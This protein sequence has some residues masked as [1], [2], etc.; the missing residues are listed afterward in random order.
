MEALRKEELNITNDAIKY[1][2]IIAAAIEDD[3]QRKR[4]FASIIALDTFAD[5]LVTKGISVNISKNL[6]K[7]APVNAEFEIAD[8]YY[9]GWKLDVR[10]VGDDNILTIP[11]VHFKTGITADFYVAVKVD[12]ELKNAVIIGY[13]DSSLVNKKSK[14]ESYY[15]VGLEDLSPTADLL[16]KIKVNNDS[17]VEDTKHDAFESSYLGYIDNEINEK[18]K[19][20]LIKHL[21][22]CKQCRESFVEFFDFESIVSKA[23]KYPELFEDQTLSI[24]SGTVINDEN[25]KGQELVI[26]INDDTQDADIIDGLFSQSSVPPVI[27]AGAAFSADITAPDMPEISSDLTGSDL[28]ESIDLGDD[29]SLGKESDLLIS[30]EEQESVVSE[31]ELLDIEGTTSQVLDDIL[32]EPETQNSELKVEDDFDEILNSEEIIDNNDYDFLNSDDEV[33]NLIPTEAENSLEDNSTEEDTDG[34]FASDESNDELLEKQDDTL[35]EDNI[36]EEDF[37]ENDFI[38]T[39][40]SFIEESFKSEESE[41]LLTEELPD[42]SNFN[43]EQDVEEKFLDNSFDNDEDQS[44]QESDMFQ[45]KFTE[46]VVDEEAIEEVSENDFLTADSIVEDIS[47]Q[48]LDDIFVETPS[49]D[50]NLEEVSEIIEPDSFL[51][52]NN[53]ILENDLMPEEDSDMNITQESF[54]NINRNEISLS[55]ENKYENLEPFSDEPE[56]PS[57]LKAIFNEGEKQFEEVELL[58][59]SFQ[60]ID[61]TA[62]NAKDKKMIKLASIVIGCVLLATILGISLFIHNNNKK[63]ELVNNQIAAQSVD[64]SFVPPAADGNN[65]SASSPED[66]L[67]SPS[68]NVPKDMNKAM[69]NVFSDTPS[70]VTVTKIAWEVPLSLSK[71]AT[72]KK[73]LQISGQNLQLNLKNDLIN[74]TEFAYNDKVGVG[75][76]ISG[77]GQIKDTKILNT[78]GSSQVDQIVLQSI[79]ETLQYINIPIIATTDQSVANAQSKTANDMGSKNNKL[80]NLK[81]VINF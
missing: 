65:I 3:I 25:Y 7:I 73:F 6:F 19:K 37:S 56:D 9:N 28:I 15:L 36:V 51:T 75:I 16:E 44:L 1:A 32:A 69:T 41:T 54:L 72:F 14:D 48:D 52:S 38:E 21:F 24:I 58:E 39:E 13:L 33:E 49:A 40:A 50:S 59:G 18:N 64:N 5:Y 77:D 71:D 29:I 23:R 11:Q 42:D 68:A 70:S 20:R 45:E 80:Y 78:S 12:K 35:V 81:L 30:D 31:N 22:N 66:I 57:G 34:L 10:V 43:L 4:A 47:E 63:T 60:S 46:E 27:L 79:K 26:D 55:E 2:R 74:A 61:L 67:K 62:A 53:N 8:I 76:V 17:Y